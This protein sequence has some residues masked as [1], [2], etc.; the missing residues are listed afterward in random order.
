MKR[1]LVAVIMYLREKFSNDTEV[2]D[3]V[4]FLE[5]CLVDIS[6]NTVS[7]ERTVLGLN[8]FLIRFFKA[9]IKKKKWE[10]EHILNDLLDIFT[11]NF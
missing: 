5:D 1:K 2:M 3:I 8:A 4:K 7:D 9:G 6:K 10:K 11:D